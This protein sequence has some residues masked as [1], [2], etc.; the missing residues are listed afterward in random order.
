[1]IRK[2][3]AEQSGSKLF[4]SHSHKDRDLVGRLVGIV[5]RL[6]IVPDEAIIC[7]SLSDCGLVLGGQ[8]DMS[9]RLAINS[10]GLVLVLVSSN[11][12]SASW[13]PFELGAAWAFK[14]EIVPLNGD[15]TTLAL[16]PLPIQNT[17]GIRLEDPRALERLVQKIGKQLNWDAR[18]LS[19][20][21]RN[22]AL[23]DFTVHVRERNVV[24][25]DPTHWPMTLESLI[26]E[27]KESPPPSERKVS[28]SIDKQEWNNVPEFLTLSGTA[29]GDLAGS[30][31]WVLCREENQASHY[32]QGTGE[33]VQVM[34]GKWTLPGI[35]IGAANVPHELT[36]VD[37]NEPIHRAFELY[38]K[39]GRLQNRWIGFLGLDVPGTVKLAAVRV[40]RRR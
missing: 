37:A 35:R 13:I 27:A 39:I 4:I 40:I 20:D 19:T 22:S 2:E 31:L 6:L 15:D 12:V 28:V 17:N 38:F 9:L 30:R 11:C 21:E 36:V 34:N 25:F 33:S 24:Q 16:L 23:L 5:K 10:A 18:S 1:M 3:T 8:L 14:K 29:R 7:T 26:Q 32:P